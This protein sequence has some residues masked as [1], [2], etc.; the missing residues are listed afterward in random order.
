[1]HPRHPLQAGSRRGRPRRGPASTAVRL[2]SGVAAAD[3]TSP[4]SSSGRRLKRQDSRPSGRVSTRAD[5]RVP[6]ERRNRADARTTSARPF[7]RHRDPCRP[8]RVSRPEIAPPPPAYC[9]RPRYSLHSV[10]ECRRFTILRNH[11]QDVRGTGCA[12]PPADFRAYCRDSSA[13]FGIDPVERIG[14]RR[15]RA[16]QRLVEAWAEIHQ[17]ELATDWR[18]LQAGRSPL[19]NDPSQ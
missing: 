18:L 8:A 3:D 4:S 14:G 7:R 13:V 5:R 12:P 11:H 1:M 16:Q 6:T 9:K 10:T 15:P 17:A 2:R 19:K